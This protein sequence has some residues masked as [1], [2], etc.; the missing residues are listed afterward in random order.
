MIHSLDHEREAAGPVVA[1]PGEQANS[2]RIAPGHQ[3][4]AV[5]LDLVNPV[6]P[7][8]RLVGGRWEAR[9]NEAGGDGPGERIQ[10]GHARK[11]GS[12][13]AEGKSRYLKATHRQRK[14][15]RAGRPSGASRRPRHFAIEGMGRRPDP[16][17][18]ESNIADLKLKLAEMAPDNVANLQS[19]ARS[20]V[21]ILLGL[22]PE[23]PRDFA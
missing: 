21:D 6:R 22:K 5:V 12:V 14:P 17:R 2:Y 7:R 18:S 8:R 19:V 3:A 15:R 23:D 1:V 10:R 20:S 13:Q 9:F 4:I 16:H 11:I